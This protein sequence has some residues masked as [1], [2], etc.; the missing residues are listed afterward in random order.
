[1]EPTY[2]PIPRNRVLSLDPLT[3]GFGFVVL[4]DGPLQLVDWGV[5]YCAKQKQ[6]ACSRAVR[7]MLGEF[8]PTALVIERAASARSLRAFAL[9]G[10]LG[11]IADALADSAV[12]LRAYSRLD[13]R[14]AFAPSGAV[15]K[16]QIATVLV[17][18]FPE[19][20]AKAPRERK[21]WESEDT[22]MAIFDALAFALTHLATGDG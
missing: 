16:A 2:E 17:S 3:R 14:R 12:D 10:F 20:R 18:R 7:R 19:L 8:A 5:R 9:E 21:L 22:R 13:V 1:M 15:T 4:E 11:G 6:E